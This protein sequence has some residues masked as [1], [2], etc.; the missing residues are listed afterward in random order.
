MCTALPVDSVSRFHQLL[1]SVNEHIQFML[2]EDG[3]L[4]F[5]D[6]LLK[7]NPDSIQTSVY[8]NILGYLDFHSHH[9]LSQKKSDYNTPHPCQRSL[10]QCY[11]PEERNHVVT[12]LEGMGTPDS[13]YVDQHHPSPC[14]TPWKLT[15][16]GTLIQ[17][18]WQ[19]KWSGLQDP[20]QGL[21]HDMLNNL[22]T[23]WCVEW[24]STREQ[25]GMV[26]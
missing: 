12:A 2:E 19:C 16:L 24:R 13:S 18:R 14:H 6:V 22:A 17:K 26:T 23:P 11:W 9:A 8:R 25:S 10:I 3:C 7:R 1:N 21:H 20:L 5:L 15:A 4:P